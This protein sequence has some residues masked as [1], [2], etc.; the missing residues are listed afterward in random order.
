MIRISLAAHRRPDP[1]R[2]HTA[3]N[4]PDAAGSSRGGGC[5]AASESVSRSK[6][7]TVPGRSLSPEPIRPQAPAPV[8]SIVAPSPAAKGGTRRQPERDPAQFT[9]LREGRFELEDL[10]RL[11]RMR[12][13]ELP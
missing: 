5:G 12:G 6:G 9:M 4:A 11:A 2:G 13:M 8:A 10:R 1:K 7:A 3:G